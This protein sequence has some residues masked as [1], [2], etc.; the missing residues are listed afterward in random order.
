MICPTPSVEAARVPLAA[1]CKALGDNPRDGILARLVA[2]GR[3][4]APDAKGRVMLAE[5]VGAYFETVRAD[6][7]AATLTAGA[8]RAREA[9]AEAAE[10]QLQ[11]ARRDLVARDDA[12]AAT[13]ALCGEILTAFSGLAARITRDVRTR[14]RIEEI[15][16][17]AQAALAREVAG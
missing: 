7:R 15:T 9:R 6:L 8:E 4:T 3:I 12:E 2:S 1:L 10:L 11:M 14:R 17:A 16:R 13:D 5:A